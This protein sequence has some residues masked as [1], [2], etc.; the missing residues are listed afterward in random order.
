MRS[1]K[2]Q[3]P[4]DLTFG[5]R[6]RQHL[7]GVVEP[8]EDNLHLAFSEML[9]APQFQH[10]LEGLLARY[11]APKKLIMELDNAR[12]HYSKELAPFLEANKNGLELVFL[13]PYSPDLNPMEWFWKFLRKIITHNTFFPT[14]KDFQRALIKFIVKHKSFL[15]EIKIRCSYVKSFNSP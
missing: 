15:P 14:F 12:A 1:L 8:L 13:P 3:Q 5:G 2:G 4:K 7:I 6:K 9:K 11:P 10:Y